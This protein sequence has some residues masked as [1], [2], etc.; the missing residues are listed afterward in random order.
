MGPAV[1][2][3]AADA[4]RQVIELAAQR[5]DRPEER[6]CPCGA[7]R[8]SARTAA[9][10]RST[11][12]T[13]LL[14]DGQILGKGARGPNPTGMRV[15]TFGIQLAEVAVDIGTGEVRRREGSSRSTTSAA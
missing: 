13:G 7:A 4:A 9:S 6:R 8:S 10:G 12:I 2:S 5:F 3:A 11:T 14:D 15:L 1:R